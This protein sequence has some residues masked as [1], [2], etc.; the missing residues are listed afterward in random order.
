VMSG[1]LGAGLG[2]TGLLGGFFGVL[3]GITGGV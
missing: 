2:G 1:V 3:Y